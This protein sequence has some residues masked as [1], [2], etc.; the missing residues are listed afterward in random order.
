MAPV[1]K[2]IRVPELSDAMYAHGRKSSRSSPFEV[3]AARYSRA[4]DTLQLTLRNEIVVSLP[5][6]RIRELAKALPADLAKVEIQ[7]GGDGITFRSINVDISVP[8]LI[9]DEF[10]S[11]FARELGRKTKGQTSAVKVAASRENGRKGGRPKKS[12]A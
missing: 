6:R 12:A 3:V 9:A 5:R 11:L 7:P 1:P 10:G 4:Y 2:R 8:G